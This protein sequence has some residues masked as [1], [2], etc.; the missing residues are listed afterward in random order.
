[1]ALKKLKTRSLQ[2]M[3]LVNGNVL[4][5]FSGSWCEVEASVLRGSRPIVGEGMVQNCYA[6][7]QRKIGAM[8]LRTIYCE[9]A[10]RSK[11]LR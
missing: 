11:V 6:R 10:I 3:P 8:V 9:T 1:M 7:T 5:L 2:Y 4:L